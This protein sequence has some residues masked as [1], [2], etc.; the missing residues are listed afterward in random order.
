MLWTHLD[1]SLCLGAP[2][3]SPFLLGFAF[4]TSHSVLV[5]TR[6][7]D[8]SRRHASIALSFAHTRFPLSLLFTNFVYKSDAGALA[9]TNR[10]SARRAGAELTSVSG[11]YG[12]AATARVTRRACWTAVAQREWLPC[13]DHATTCD[14]AERRRDVRC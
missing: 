2:P 7:R 8:D 12:H 11:C 1:C 4:T 6:A 13:R 14:L 3:R 10:R 5:F 9:M